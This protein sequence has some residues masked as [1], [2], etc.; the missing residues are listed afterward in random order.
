MT[1]S[2]VAAVEADEVGT[3]IVADVC[4]Y[5]DQNCQSEWS[6]FWTQSSLGGL[7]TVSS[8]TTLVFVS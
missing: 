6:D 2:G 5:P 3:D 8:A 4:S 1:D 7:Q